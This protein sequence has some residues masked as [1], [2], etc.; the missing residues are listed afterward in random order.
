MGIGFSQN[1]G[2]PASARMD[3]VGVGG[4][5]G[6]DHDRIDR[7]QQVLG[8]RH[9]ARAGIGGD[10]LGSIGV[11]VGEHDRVHVGDRP[12]RDHVGLAHAAD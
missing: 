1:V 4:G 10:L 7:D 8:G 2:S 6:R 11:H 9:G 5:R 3:Q 12:Q